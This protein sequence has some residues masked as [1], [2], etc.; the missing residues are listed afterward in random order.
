[1][2]AIAFA[3][4]RRAQPFGAVWSDV[5]T[6]LPSSIAF[7]MLGILSG[8]L[9]TMGPL[10]LGLLVAPLTVGR[11]TYASYLRLREGYEAAL[12]VFVNAI[13]AK[14]RY[15]AGHSARVAR[16]AGYI[17]EELGFTSTDLERLRI[18]ALLHDIGK[19]AV[20]SRLLNKPGRL[21]PEEYEQVQLHNRAAMQILGRV[22]FLRDAIPVAS[23]RHA[24]F[25]RDTDR[26]DPWAMTGYAVA[27]ADAFDAMTSTRA[28]RRA[29]PQDVAFAEL[30]DKAGTQ[31]H[32]A[33][34]DALIRAVER[35]GERYGAGHERDVVDFAVPPPE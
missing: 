34:V 15:T 14:D 3:I 9:Y 21:T 2:G 18:A 1:T 25:D 27:V 28:Y 7:G 24:H 13:D 35:R 12:G 30:R 6:V 5:R 19:L 10:A 16:F 23:D 20:P 31:F 29:L 26:D 11:W 22:D 8:W 32:P 17:G 33:C 4:T